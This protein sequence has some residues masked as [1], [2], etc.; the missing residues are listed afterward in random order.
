V[1]VVLAGIAPAEFDVKD[2]VEPETQETAEE[3]V[4]RHLL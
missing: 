2:P 1:T 3:L 4:L